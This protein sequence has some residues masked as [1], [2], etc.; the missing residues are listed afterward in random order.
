MEVFS[1]KANGSFELEP[2]EA[3][4]AAEAILMVYIHETHGP[5]PSLRLQAHVSVD[6]VRWIDFAR[7]FDLISETGGYYFTLLH[8]G[9]WLRIRGQVDGGP[10]SGDPSL[11]ADFYWVFKS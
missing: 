8:F 4:W 9:N 1:P 3:G 5:S 2:H 7:P 10:E 6:G 11:V